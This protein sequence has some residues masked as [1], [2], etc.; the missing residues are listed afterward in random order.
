MAKAEE[1]KVER[2]RIGQ[3]THTIFK[4]THPYCI[5]L[6]FAVFLISLKMFHMVLTKSLFHHFLQF[7]RVHVIQEEIQS[8][9]NIQNLLDSLMSV[10]F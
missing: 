7:H 9:L 8:I 6:T 2:A 1:K 4:E 3:H 10:C 5:L